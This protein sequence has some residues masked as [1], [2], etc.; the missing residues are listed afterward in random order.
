MDLRR[1]GILF[2]LLVVTLALPA[3]V[4]LSPPPLLV[5]MY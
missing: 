2:G 5:L 4:S 1:G 3:A